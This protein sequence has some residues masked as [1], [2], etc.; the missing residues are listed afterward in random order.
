MRRLRIYVDTSVI[1]GCFDTE[2]S[3]ASRAL[4][5]LSRLGQVTLLVSD[6]L[7]EELLK[8]PREVRDLLE[9][10]PDYCLERVS[11]NWESLRLRNC[12][13][14]S[15]VIGPSSSSDAHHVAIATVFSADLLVS[16]N[17]KHIVHYAKIR[18]YSGVN[19]IEGYSPIEI[20]TPREVV[21]DAE[22]QEI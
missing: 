15:G 6:I 18:G 2:F 10:L 17:F 14:S 13:L 9:S 11:S 3:Q 5:A 7:I 21:F 8:A 16:W 22:D 1:G 20:R 4:I 12:Y 19:L